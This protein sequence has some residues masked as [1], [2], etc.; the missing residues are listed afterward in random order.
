MSVN[1]EVSTWQCWCYV[2]TKHQHKLEFVLDEANERNRPQHIL[3]ASSQRIGQKH[4]TYAQHLWNMLDQEFAK[5]NCGRL[6]ETQE[7]G[8]LAFGIEADS[9]E[10]LQHMISLSDT[11][12]SRWINKYHINSMID[13][14][15]RKIT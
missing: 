6:K 9:A 15:I 5:T 11:V 12:I 10:Q 3:E 4:T 13:I 7:Y 2:V 8:E 1:I 14:D